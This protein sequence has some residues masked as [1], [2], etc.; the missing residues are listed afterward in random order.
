MRLFKYKVSFILVLFLVLSSIATSKD[1]NEENV[2]ETSENIE[3]DQFEEVDA[4]N[5]KWEEVLDPIDLKRAKKTAEFLFPG[6]KKYTGEFKDDFME[7]MN[8]RNIFERHF[9]WKF[10]V[11]N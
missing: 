7:L 3:D 4:E 11:V 6:I 2:E 9:Y 10:D 1:Q 5:L 8:V